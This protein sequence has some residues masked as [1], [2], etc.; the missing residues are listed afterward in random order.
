MQVLDVQGRKFSVSVK[1]DQVNFIGENGSDASRLGTF[2]TIWE[3]VETN[4]KYQ[5]VL[6]IAQGTSLCQPNDEYNFAIGT[7]QAATRAL[8]ALGYRTNIHPVVKAVHRLV[9][10]YVANSAAQFGF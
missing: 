5:H 10:D 1:V 7:R 2:V 8:D 6:P 9:K 3:H 4:R